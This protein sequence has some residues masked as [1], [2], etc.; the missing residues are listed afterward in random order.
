MEHADE[1]LKQDGY[2]VRKLDDLDREFSIKAQQEE[3]A[4]RLRTQDWMIRFQRTCE[5]RMQRE[6]QAQLKM[7]Q[8]AQ[9]E[10][11]RA[12]E[13][14]RYQEEVAKLKLEYEKRMVAEQLALRETAAKLESQYRARESV[15]PAWKE[16]KLFLDVPVGTGRQAS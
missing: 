15:S 10:A 1:R 16:A 3:G 2:L 6:L 11:M 9:V 14:L 4:S 13:R 12:D 5:E 7:H 8:E